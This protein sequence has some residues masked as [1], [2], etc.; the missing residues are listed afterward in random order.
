MI[1][2]SD[3]D[4]GL[5]PLSGS[6]VDQMLLPES[7]RVMQEPVEYIE[8]DNQARGEVNTITPKLHFSI[9]SKEFVPNFVLPVAERVREEPVVIVI[10]EAQRVVDTQVII[11][12][13]NKGCFHILPDCRT[14]PSSRVVTAR[15]RWISTSRSWLGTPR[16]RPWAPRQWG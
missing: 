8:E 2:T 1:V 6:A 7:D 11:N 4:E 12:S 5:K 15:S 14:S 3:D 13:K 9:L 16:T 10:P